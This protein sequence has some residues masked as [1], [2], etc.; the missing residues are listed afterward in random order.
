MVRNGVAGDEFVRH[1]KFYGQVGD[2]QII[3]RERGL[4]ELGRLSSSE[5]GAVFAIYI[6]LLGRYPNYPMAVG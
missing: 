6:Y 5:L 2:H 1:G 4:A 3:C